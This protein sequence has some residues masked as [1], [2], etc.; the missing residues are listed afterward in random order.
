MKLLSFS[1]LIFLFGCTTTGPEKDSEVVARVYDK[2]LTRKDLSIVIPENATQRDSLVVTENFIK[3]WVQ[4]QLIL[5]KATEN[6]TSEEIDF[7]SELEEYKNSLIIYAYESKL[8]NEYLDT[9]VSMDEI[10][11]YY[12]D[13]LDN[14]ELTQPVVRLNYIRLHRDVPEI[15]RFRSLIKS[16]EEDDIEELT[17]MCTQ[18][19]DEFWL[20]DD[21]IYFGEIIERIPYSVEDYNKF[22]TRNKNIQVLVNDNWYLLHI[23]GYKLKGDIAPLELEEE[24]IRKIIINNRKLELKRDLRKD[25]MEAA[26]EKN[27]L[28]IY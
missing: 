7:S 5:K 15:P 4:Q 11:G 27:E 24:S 13:H 16:E 3:N 9:V 25:L 28:V 1:I 22:L 20:E 10:S 2:T 23:R 8:V 14:F 17:E 26:I 12:N 19:A 21:W 18:Y 6:L